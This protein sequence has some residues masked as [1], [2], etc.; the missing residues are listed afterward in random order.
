MKLALDIERGFRRIRW[1]FLGLAWA[2]F[3]I[4]HAKGN[5]SAFEWGENAVYMLFFTGGCV[6]VA[7]LVLWVF[8]GFIREPERTDSRDVTKR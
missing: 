1:T 2:F 6:L 7:R 4:V 8:R 3:V 5:F